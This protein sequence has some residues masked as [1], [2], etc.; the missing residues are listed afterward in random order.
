MD[1]D[2]IRYIK[3]KMSYYPT[4]PK[5]LNNIY[6]Y[7][8]KPPDIDYPNNIK[9][10]FEYNYKY[11]FDNELN[12]W[13]FG[14]DIT[15]N[16]KWSILKDARN[17]FSLHAMINELLNRNHFYDIYWKQKFYKTFKK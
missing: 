14:L 4:L 1:K 11:I 3:L 7:G 6:F 16:V 15:R 5:Y 8:C 13:I 17:G 9:Y 10:F 12:K 2:K